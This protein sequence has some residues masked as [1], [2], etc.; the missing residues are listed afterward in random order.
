LRY[1]CRTVKTTAPI[2]F[3]PAPGKTPV[4]SGRML[5]PESSHVGVPFAWLDDLVQGNDLTA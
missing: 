4:D 2:R 3:V 5:P 1:L